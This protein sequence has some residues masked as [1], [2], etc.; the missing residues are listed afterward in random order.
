MKNIA[1]ISLFET[2]RYQTHFLFFCEEHRFEEFVDKWIAQMKQ[3]LIKNNQDELSVLRDYF[4]I[5]T[6]VQFNEWY[7]SEK[8]YEDYNDDDN[9]NY[10]EVTYSMKEYL[11]NRKH[12]LPLNQLSNLSV[13]DGD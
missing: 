4:G 9:Y 1:T 8:I 5:K 2:E 11:M 10:T 7:D 12:L 13:T 6:L 3:H